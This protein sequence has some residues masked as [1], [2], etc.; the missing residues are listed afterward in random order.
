VCNGG[1]WVWDDS[2]AGA[3]YERREQNLPLPDR[4]DL[5]DVTLP[6]GNSIRMVKPLERYELTYSDPGKLELE[7]VFQAIMP[8]HSHPEGT[9]PFVKGRHFDQPG[10]VT[11]WMELYGERVTVDCF[12]GRDRSWGPRPLGPDP[13]K[14]RPAGDKPKPT[15]PRSGVGYGYAIAD[16]ANAFLAYTIPDETGRDDVS[17]GY[18]LRDGIYA[19]LAGGRRTV[20][21]Q[22]ET[23]FIDTVDVTATDTLGRELIAHGELVAR[24]GTSGPSGTGLFQW[25]WNDGLVGWGE[26]QSYC[27][28]GIWRAQGAPAVAS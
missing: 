17:A 16:D 24:H 27:S 1:A 10:R 9:P 7:L 3:L 14:P 4:G 5:R 28:E 11:G 21:F 15:G 13:R 18:L 26:D 19:P 22:P 12:F 2:P 8:P 20:R 23:R 6:N 25:R